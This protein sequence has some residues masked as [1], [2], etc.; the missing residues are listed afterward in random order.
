MR[1]GHSALG[2]QG[3]FN[4]GHEW[5]VGDKGLVDFVHVDLEGRG[6]TSTNQGWEGWGLYGWS[7][8]SV[9]CPVYEYPRGKGR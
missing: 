6:P 1:Q 9:T 8:S 2:Y 4:V 7:F 3:R 5:A